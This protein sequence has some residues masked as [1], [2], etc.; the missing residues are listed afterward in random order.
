MSVNSQMRKG[1]LDHFTIED[2]NIF[3]DYD[4][5]GHCKVC[6]VHIFSVCKLNYVLV[7]KEPYYKYMY[8]LLTRGIV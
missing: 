7:R 1:F 5:Q 8:F 4:C 3:N 2:W 6:P